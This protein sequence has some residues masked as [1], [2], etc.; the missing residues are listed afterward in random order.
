MTKVANMAPS[1]PANFSIKGALSQGLLSNNT[2]VLTINGVAVS[3]TYPNPT[4]QHLI[5]AGVL[6]PS[7]PASILGLSGNF[8]G[9]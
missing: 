4:V 6:D 8:G 1:L 9:D 3:K 5:S 7:K 2:H